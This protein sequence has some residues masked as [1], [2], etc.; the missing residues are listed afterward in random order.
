MEAV[1]TSTMYTN[2][3]GDETAVIVCGDCAF[4]ALL[5]ANASWWQE[6]DERLGEFA[7]RQFA[8]A[9]AAL[10]AIDAFIRDLSKKG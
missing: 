7:A 9:G 2:V 5:E 6:V 10:I 4:F 8:I 1:A 3:K